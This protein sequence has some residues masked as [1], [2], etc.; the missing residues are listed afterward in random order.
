MVPDFQM[1]FLKKRKAAA[2]LGVT[3]ERPEAATKPGG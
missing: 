3:M 1:L 2:G